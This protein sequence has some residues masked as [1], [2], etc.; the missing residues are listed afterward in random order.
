MLIQ[1]EDKCLLERVISGGQTGADQAGLYSAEACRFKTGGHAPKG[2]RTL[3]GNNPTMLRDH[4]GLEETVQENYQYRTA[5][6]V[7]NS[8]ATI[9]LAS[10]FQSPGELCTLRAITKFKK[11]YFDIDLRPLMR[12]K[13]QYL[14]GRADR[15]AYIQ[16]TTDA[17]L[18]FLIDHQVVTLNIAGNAD[19]NSTG[20][21][22][23]H[24]HS[25]SEVLIDLFTKVR[26][27]NESLQRLS[28]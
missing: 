18:A 9:R 15:N 28:A 19:R 27:K 3:A 17:I 23:E 8:D 7:Q 16:K 22:G 6:N 21:F 26:N 12:N 2:Y 4:F 11:P 20:G 25:A 5:L 14:S 24:F 1:Y 10:D 13:M